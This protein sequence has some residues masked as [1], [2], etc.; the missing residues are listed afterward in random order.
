MSPIAQTKLLFGTLGLSLLLASCGSNVAQNAGQTT[1]T[2]SKTV[3][4]NQNTLSV[5]KVDRSEAPLYAA[6]SKDAIP[7]QYIVV[8]KDGSKGQI[9]TQSV[10]G[11]IQSLG[12]NPAG[13]TV[14]SR[15][16]SALSGFAGKINAEN[17]SKLRHNRNV[18][19]VQQDTW[20]YA[21]ATQN[22]PTWGLDRIDQTNLPLDGKYNYASA[23]GV[24][25]YIVDTG[26]RTTHQAFGGRAVWGANFTGDNTNTDCAGHGTH[27]AGTVGS[28]TWGVAKDVNI[29]AVK[30]LGCDGRGAN[31]WILNGL[32]W[33]ARQNPGGRKVV[34][35]SLGPN[36]RYTDYSE[37]S[38]I[39]N[40]VAKG[41]PMVLAAGNNNDDACE[42]SP[43]RAVDAITV[44]ATD[45][46]DNRSDFSNWGSCLDIF[47]P[48]TDITS[49]GISSDTSYATMS[50]TSM[51]TP[52]VTGAVALLLAQNPNAT[53]YQISDL[54]IK[55]SSKNKVSDT[56]GSVNRLLNVTGSGSTTP[57]NPTPTNPTTN[58]YTGNL[59]EGYEAYSP[60]FT[61]G[62]AGANLS[63][64]LTATS[65]GVD[66][67]LYLQRQSGSTWV[68]AASYENEGNEQASYRA[69]AGTYRW[70]VYAYSGSGSFRLSETH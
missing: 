60:S 56:A 70:A 50:G 5:A 63:A 25:A 24:T 35:M 61:V 15:Y 53:A 23:K 45:R 44:G 16:D 40:M 21:S 34:N 31:S 52:H 13:I 62:S 18:K 48:G 66:F 11:M 64:T 59:N 28:G 19:Y 9:Q 68:D 12:L 41:I 1:P 22:S 3:T 33:V 49:A 55:N 30:V 4:N 65:N 10:G 39:N 37:D 7:G 69:S 58:T 42:Y 2:A 26:I 27:V 46:Y 47:A 38:A 36:D 32:D 67:D 43:G 17:L 29:V 57:T 14:E 54:L 8:F 20:M 51:A 6:G